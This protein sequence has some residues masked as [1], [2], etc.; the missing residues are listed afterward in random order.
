MT[1]AKSELQCALQD[2]TDDR[3]I[4][5]RFGIMISAVARWR[6]GVTAPHDALLPVILQWLKDN[7]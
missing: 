7:K 5:D 6:D 2:R 4:A 3:E 1:E